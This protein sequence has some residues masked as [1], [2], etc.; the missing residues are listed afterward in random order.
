MST[1]Y[2]PSD[3]LPY[4]GPNRDSKNR[5]GRDG[6]EKKGKHCKI[7]NVI[8]ALR[9]SRNLLQQEKATK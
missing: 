8:T 5:R 9:Q 7:C 2:L 4:E 3:I 1:G 6:K